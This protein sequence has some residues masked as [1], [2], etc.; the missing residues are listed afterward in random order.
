METPNAAP[1]TCMLRST[2]FYNE[3]VAKYEDTNVSPPTYRL[4]APHMRVRLTKVINITIYV[5]H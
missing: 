5:I 2:A 3:K 1:P 4:T